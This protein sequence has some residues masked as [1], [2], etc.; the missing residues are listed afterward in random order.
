M[1][2]LPKGS[3]VYPIIKVYGYN[4]VPFDGDLIETIG[5]L[6]VEQTLVEWEVYETKSFS[7]LNQYLLYD[8]GLHKISSHFS[9][10]QKEDTPLR[11]RQINGNT[12]EVYVQINFPAPLVNTD[13]KIGHLVSLG[14]PDMCVKMLGDVIGFVVKTNSLEYKTEDNI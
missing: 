6:V 12:T 5:T 3:L 7:F 9:I 11:F 10:E 4:K 13:I 14:K 8:T 1:I 2:T